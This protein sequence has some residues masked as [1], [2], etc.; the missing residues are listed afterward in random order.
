MTIQQ[1][2]ETVKK[3]PEFNR[4]GM[5][6]THNGVVRATTREGTPT[7]GLEV[8][9]RRERLAGVLEEARARPGIVEVL[10]HINEGR[11]APG[12]DVMLVTVA[13]DI[14]DNVFPALMETVNRLKKEVII[15]TELL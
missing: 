15:K 12:D 7:R 9:F 8:S 1:Q 4:V 13:G 6:L 10:I 14:R 11:L 2:I 3:H 5:I